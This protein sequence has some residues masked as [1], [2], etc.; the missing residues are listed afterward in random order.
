MAGVYMETLPQL[1]V[2]G[3]WVF[4]LERFAVGAAGEEDEFFEIRTEWSEKSIT[5]LRR[6]YH[7]LV[8]LVRN[9]II[10]FPD[11]R[12]RLSQS[13]MLEALQRIKEAERNN[14]VQTRLDEVEKLLRS[15]M[16]MPQKFSHSEAVLKFFKTSPFDYTLKTMYEPI[17]PLYQSPVTVADVRRANGF[18]LANTETV[19]FDAYL[20]AQGA[21]PS[22]KYSSE[23]ESQMWTGTEIQNR[24]R[25]VKETV[26]KP[27]KGFMTAGNPESKD[28]DYQPKKSQITNSNMTYL[29]LQACETDILE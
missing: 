3:F 9:L 16:K 10:S 28:T 18:C 4:G 13:M 20:Q 11:D 21:E 15:I 26:H 17:Q 19:L 2:N 12:G 7:D 24:I 1:S 6:R 23:N 29:H 27:G 8:K 14:N 25:C 22:L 5:Y